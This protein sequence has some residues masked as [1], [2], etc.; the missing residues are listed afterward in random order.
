MIGTQNCEHCRERFLDC[1]DLF[2]GDAGVEVGGIFVLRTG[3]KLTEVIGTNRNRKID[4]SLTDGKCSAGGNES[5]NEWKGKSELHRGKRAW[6]RCGNLNENEGLSQ[7]QTALYVV[8][9]LEL[10]HGPKSRRN[11]NAA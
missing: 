3:S 6:G 7:D 9:A 1:D 2:G 10:H 11:M 8:A 4:T 5:G